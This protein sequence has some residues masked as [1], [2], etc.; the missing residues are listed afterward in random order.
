[1][2]HHGNQTLF[3]AAPAT[4]SV[5]I[6]TNDMAP[7]ATLAECHESADV[8]SQAVQDW[9]AALHADELAGVEA[10]VGRGIP[11]KVIGRELPRVERTGAPSIDAMALVAAARAERRRRQ[12]LTEIGLRRRGDPPFD[13]VAQVFLPEARLRA[14]QETPTAVGEQ[15]DRQLGRGDAER[16]R[17]AH[18]PLDTQHEAL[19]WELAKEEARQD[20][21]GIAAR[22]ATREELDAVTSELSQPMHPPER[23][24]R[25]AGNVAVVNA[26]GEPISSA[27]YFAEQGRSPFTVEQWCA[28]PTR[29]VVLPGETPPAD[30]AGLA[31][32]LFN[33]ILYSNQ[34]CDRNGQAVGLSP[35]MRAD[36]LARITHAIEEGQ[37]IVASEYAPLV[38]I[39]NPIKRNTQTPSLTEIDMLRRLSETAHAV[40]LYYPPGMHWLLGNEATVFQGPH[41]G[42]PEGYVEQFH[43]QCQDLARLVDPEGRRLTVF[44]QSDLNWGTPERRAQWEVYEARRLAELRTAYEDPLHPNH[45]ATKEY[46][47]TYIYPMATCISP[48]QF[49]AAHELS[50]RQIAE[51]YEVLKRSRGSVIRGVGSLEEQSAEPTVLTPAQRQLL[52]DLEDKA[53]ALTYQY[54]VTMDSRDELSAFHEFIPP[55]TIK[56]TMVTK[57]DKLV[58][59]PNSGRGAYFPA[60][61]EPVLVR[62]KDPRQRTAVTVRPWWHIAGAAEQ[63]TPMYVD[64]RDEPLYFEQRTA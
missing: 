39:S 55:D 11:W 57:R 12:V 47:D 27:A 18:A 38:A 29:P 40:E 37:P 2:T 10:E 9:S 14:E 48:Y 15:L 22:D 62:P 33:R 30:P 19:A 50:V 52:T 8:L 28:L 51:V 13:Q 42:L 1:M 6:G 17:L 41:F 31:A 3:E 25:D 7:G 32:F 56:Y 4:A 59:Y 23:P 24:A 36:Y 44:D 58:L 43:E 64:G 49:G 34:V 45:A 16:K 53:L 60:H 35:A 21:M 20:L 46:V 63:Y 26:S 61:G 54:R 5:P